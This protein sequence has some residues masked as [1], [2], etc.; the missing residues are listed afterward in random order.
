MELD[1]ENKYEYIGMQKGDHG[2]CNGFEEQ[3][4]WYEGMPPNEWIFDL[5][6]QLRE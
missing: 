5:W 2:W 1:R 3:I 6:V 4:N